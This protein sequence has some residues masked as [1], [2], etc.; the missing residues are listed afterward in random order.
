MQIQIKRE[1]Y[2]EKIEWQRRIPWERERARGMRENRNGRMGGKNNG[3][4][5][6][7][8]EKREQPS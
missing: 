6:E 4:G 5:E 7:L 8:I 3:G 1:R 2:S